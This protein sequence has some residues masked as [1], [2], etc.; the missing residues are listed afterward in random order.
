M[1]T[2]SKCKIEKQNSEF[3]FKDKTKNKLQS[4]CKYCS[5]NARMESYFKNKDINYQNS[6]NRVKRNRK[7]VTSYLENHSCVDCGEDDV[8]VLEFDHVNHNK[9]YN[10]SSMVYMQSSIEKISIEIEKC[11]VRC[12]NCHRRVTHERRNNSLVG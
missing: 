10:I 1:K 3:R 11:E 7:F 8:I 6:K 4:W 5:N 12:A 2:C 9:L